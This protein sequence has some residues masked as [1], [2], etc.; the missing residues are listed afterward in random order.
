L[1]DPSQD[2]V[3]A[4][5][6]IRG[7][8]TKEIRLLPGKYKMGIAFIKDNTSIVIPKEEIC[9]DSGV[10]GKLLNN[11]ECKDVGP[12]TVS[13]D[14]AFTTQYEMNVEF[15]D[16]IYQDSKMVFTGLYFNLADAEPKVHD[17]LSEW[18]KSNKYVIQSPELF[19]PAFIS[20]G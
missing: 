16:M 15:T 10:L 17:D 3:T 18:S 12:T 4:V 7:A 6:D 11:D 19:R 14:S 8:E 5:A 1:D 13:K 20:T 2:E 9:A